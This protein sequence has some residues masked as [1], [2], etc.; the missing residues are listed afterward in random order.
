M[1][2][3]L[4][5]QWYSTMLVIRR[6][7]WTNMRLILNKIASDN[8][9]DLF[10]SDWVLKPCFS[11]IQEKHFKILSEVM[12]AMFYHCGILQDYDVLAIHGYEQFLKALHHHIVMGNVTINQL[13]QFLILMTYMS[14]CRI[15]HYT[16]YMRNEDDINLEVAVW[17]SIV[18]MAFRT[19]FHAEGS[20]R[21]INPYFKVL[22]TII[23]RR[24][25]VIITRY[26]EQECVCQ[27]HVQSDLFP[28]T[29]TSE[30]TLP[31]YQHFLQYLQEKGFS[32]FSVTS[33]S[34]ALSK[35]GKTI[36]M[37]VLARANGY[38][39]PYFPETI[40]E[41]E[42]KCLYGTNFS[43]PERDFFTNKLLKVTP[44][45]SQEAVNQS[46]A[47]LERKKEANC[48]CTIHTQKRGH[49]WIV[50]NRLPDRIPYN[51]DDG[52]QIADSD[53]SVGI[54][55]TEDNAENEKAK[56]ADTISGHEDMEEEDNKNNQDSN[57]A[58][59]ASSENF[60]SADLT[61]GY[62]AIFN[63]TVSNSSSELSLVSRDERHIRCKKNVSKQNRPKKKNTRPTKIKT[64]SEQAELIP[65]DILEE[66]EQRIDSS[67][68]CKFDQIVYR[69]NVKGKTYSFRYFKAYK[70]DWK[71]LMNRPNG[72]PMECKCPRGR[73]HSQQCPW[74]HPDVINVPDIGNNLSTSEQ[75]AQGKIYDMYHQNTQNGQQELCGCGTAAEIAYLG[76]KS[77]CEEFQWIHERSSYE[78]LLA[79][80]KKRKKVTLTENFQ[81]HKRPRLQSPSDSGTKEEIT[82]DAHMDNPSTPT[83]ASNSLA[84]LAEVAQS[85]SSQSSLPDL[86]G[87]Q[88]GEA[89]C[90]CED[91]EEMSPL[92][93]EDITE[94]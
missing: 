51:H 17:M 43:F 77:T 9:A 24:L 35:Y 10:T 1:N 23:R 63:P 83:T 92:E 37:I 60:T 72:E 85:H 49:E 55:E 66:S 73:L 76:H 14:F 68:P 34:E 67:I 69:D 27:N 89:D 90:P 8:I 75:A 12:T 52:S 93:G 45:I 4:L 18:I 53:D 20:H 3:K 80:L 41:E 56:V 65:E 59:G 11:E 31:S 7:P 81:Q 25:H 2:P 86:I 36:T 38:Y 6:S 28:N 39:S 44:N 15:N 82:K 79:I 13:G 26:L 30:I 78:M 62:N 21:T 61:A 32:R 16:N 47:F 42:A 71:L 57:D 48:P 91:D 58:S 54:S 70:F 46:I 33:E 19:S 22:N 84:V 29:L 94:L 5:E 50:F 87:E 40:M 88:N 74:C 64:H